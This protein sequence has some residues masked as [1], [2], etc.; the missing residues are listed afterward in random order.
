MISKKRG[1]TLI[2]LLVVIAIIGILSSVVLASLN[3]ARTKGADA[4]IRSNLANARAEAEIFYDGPSTYEGVCATTGSN[5]IGDSVNA[6]EKAYGK[7]TPTTYADATASTFDTGQCHD[8]S[9]AWAAWVPLKAS[10]NGSIRAYC[11]DSTG[12]AKDVTS[13]LGANSFVCPT[14]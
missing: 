7:T 10:A 4:A 3:T 2:E 6:A 9:N 5:V 14:S 11:V 12:A 1:F 8:T 13:V